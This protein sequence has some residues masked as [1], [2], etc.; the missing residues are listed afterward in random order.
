MRTLIVGMGEVGRAHYA[1]LNDVYDTKV[2]DIAGDY[3]MP[4]K[5]DPFDILHIALNYAAMRHEN[6]IEAVRGYITICAPKIVNIL[7]TVRPGTCDE[8]G[9]NVVHSTTRGLHPNLE[10]GLRVIPKHIGGRKSE[11]VAAYFRKAGLTCITHKSAKTT[12][13]AHILNNSAYG[14]S[15]MFA[16]EMAKLCRD[17]GVDYTQAVMLYTMTNNEGFSALDQDSK[18]RMV[19][20]PP[21]GRIGGH[22]VTQGA[23]LIPW[24]LRGALM[25]KLA[26]YNENE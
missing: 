11:Q 21:G 2:Y 24:D 5:D 16:D 1:V 13:L 3:E 15:L 14:I 18:R 19:L 6:F 7:S 26:K 12:E 23:G 17:Y 10:E 8:L 9:P 25:E 4:S 22:C 20:T